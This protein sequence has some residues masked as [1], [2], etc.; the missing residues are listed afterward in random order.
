MEK[1]VDLGNRLL[2]AYEGASTGIPFG[3]VN[4]QT[5]QHKPIPWAGSSAILA[6]FG[7]VQIENRYMSKMSGKPEFAQK[8]ENVFQVLHKI[9][10]ANGLFPYFVN[11]NP[12]GSSIPKFNNDKLTFGAMA[13]S[14]YEYMLK[15]WIQGGKTEPMYREMYDKAMDGMHAELLQVSTPSNLTYIADKSTGTG[16]MDYKMDHL[17]CFMGGLLALGAYTDPTGLDSARAQRDLKTAKALTYTCYQMYARMETGISPEWIRF[18]EGNDFGPG[19]SGSHYL[20]RPETVE[21]LFILNQLTGDP[22]YREWGWEI[23]QSIEKYCRTP[24]GMCYPWSLF[25]TR[26]SHIIVIESH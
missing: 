1:A 2:K 22:V 23:F 17:V 25:E 11:N 24:H 6:E 21:S 4:L 7:T 26:L 12:G 19:P 16:S 15:I 18:R 20:L 8:T 13:D 3:E 9:S 5:G 10:P 14:F